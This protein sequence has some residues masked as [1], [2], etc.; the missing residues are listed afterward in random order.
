LPKFENLLT[1]I[2]GDVLGSLL[3]LESWYGELRECFVCCLSSVFTAYRYSNFPR[4]SDC[5]KPELPG[6]LQLDQNIKLSL[7]KRQVAL[8]DVRRYNLE[9]RRRLLA[10]CIPLGILDAAST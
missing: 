4:A 5:I 3:R 2:A 8:G 6:R 1:S 10:D 9:K 7:L